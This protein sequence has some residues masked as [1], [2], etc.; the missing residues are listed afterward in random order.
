MAKIPAKEEAIRDIRK[1]FEVR[2]ILESYFEVA[3]DQQTYYSKQEDAMLDFLEE[4]LA[5]LE[6]V[7]EIFATDRFKSMRVIPMP[8]VTAGIKLKGDLLDVS[9]NVE[10]MSAQE[11]LD[12]LA[13]YKKK[14][15]YHK[16]KSGDFIRMDENSLAVLVELNEGLH[17][18][19]EQLK[20]RKAELPLY[21][22]LYLDLLMKENADYIRVERDREFKSV[23]REMRTMEDGDYE[24]PQQIKATLRPYQE[25]GFQWLCSLAKFG[26]GGI[27]ADD[28]GLG[29]TLQVLTFLAAHP[30]SKALV[31][32]PASLV[33]NWEEECRRFYPSARTATVAGTA[34]ARQIR[35]EESET[36]DITI[37][38]YDLLK[39]DIDFYEGKRFDYMIIDEAQYIKNASTQAAKAVKAI[40]CTGRFALTGTPIEN[41]IGELWSIF[42]FLMPGYLFSYKRF[43]DELE[44]PIAECKDETARNRLS[45]FV[46]PFIMRR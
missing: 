14:K 5:Q 43:K 6:A 3:S 31:V 34:H 13:D 28:M 42:E 19:K 37:T 12:I 39:R 21:R 17:L 1:E 10:G 35:I 41:R 7:S 33:Y 38:S 2:S 27:L 45:R 44:A 8:S 4:G 23:I 11:V 30:G 46:R 9:W 18:T 29:K 36:Y 40:A 22:S 15:K 25:V 16:L 20:E 24:I 32:C 26:F